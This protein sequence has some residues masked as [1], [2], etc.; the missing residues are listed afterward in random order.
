[1]DIFALAT[2]QGRAGVAVVRISGPS[3]VMATERMC[4]TYPLCGLRRLVDAD[5]A[6]LDEALI[7]ALMQAKALPGKRSLS[8][9]TWQPRGGRSGVAGAGRY[10]RAA[11][12]EAANLPAGRWRMDSLI[13]PKLKALLTSSTQETE[14]QQK[15]AVRVFSGALGEL[16]DGWRQS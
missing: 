10:A 3:A 13:W 2:A 1:M 6:L 7:H 14:S 11:P 15:Q 5:G 16:A 4:M 9:A 12:S 8:S